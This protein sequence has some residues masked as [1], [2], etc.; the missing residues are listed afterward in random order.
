MCITCENIVTFFMYISLPSS[1]EKDRLCSY[2]SKSQNCPWGTGCQYSHD[3]KDFLSRKPADISNFCYQY[4]VFGECENGIMCRYGS[5]HINYET[6]AISLLIYSCHSLEFL[7]KK[8]TDYI[9]TSSTY[10]D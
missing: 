8:R 2:T 1:D 7:Y 3:P 4:S 6:G 10:Y 5:H 9:D